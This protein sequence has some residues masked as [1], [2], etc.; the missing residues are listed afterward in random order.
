MRSI[1][2]RVRGEHKP[3][4][5]RQRLIN[6]KNTFGTEF[7]REVFRDL[8]LRYY[9]NPIFPEGEMGQRAIGAHGVVADIIKRVGM[10]IEEFERLLRGDV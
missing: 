4:E 8:L 1:W 2:N 5:D 6:Y 7:G 10:P 3:T 9:I